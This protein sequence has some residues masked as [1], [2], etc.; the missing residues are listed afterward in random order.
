MDTYETWQAQ[1][2][3]ICHKKAYNLLSSQLI[4]DEEIL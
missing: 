1:R 3:T 4:T 2:A